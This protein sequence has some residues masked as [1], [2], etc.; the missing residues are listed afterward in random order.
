[1]MK[2]TMVKPKLLDLN[3]LTD[4]AEVLLQGASKECEESPIFFLLTCRSRS[5][6]KGTQKIV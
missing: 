4:L 5:V 6:T 3:S 1:M 2:V